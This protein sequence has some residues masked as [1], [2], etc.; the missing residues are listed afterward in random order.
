MK[1]SIQKKIIQIGLYI[2]YDIAMIA[3]AYLMAVLMFS[4]LDRPINVDGLKVA[5]PFIIIIKIVIFALTG[6]YRIMSNQLSFEDVLKFSVVNV[7]ANLLIV[8]FLALSKTEFMHKSA[9]LFISFAE[10]VLLALA[11]VVNRIIDYIK[12]HYDYPQTVGKRTLIIGAGA[13]GEAVIKELYR[14]KE[15]R[16]IPVGFL[17]DNQEKIG[18]TL[19]GVNILGP[20]D[21]IN[22]YV[23]KYNVD[24][25]IVAIN[26]FPANQF[27][28][29]E[30]LIERKSV[31]IKK[32]ISVSEYS[33]D[34]KP[35]IIDVKIDDLLERPEV[36]L[37]IERIADLIKNETVLVL[38]GGGSV[39]SELCRQIYRLSPKHLIIFDI[40]ENNAYEIQQEL[41]RQAKRLDQPLNLSV[42]IGSIY[43]KDRLQTLFE[44]FKPTVVFHAA[45]YKHVP[46]MEESAI[47]AIRTNIIGTYY[48]STLALQHEVKNFVF[49]SSDK[50]V[51]PTNMMGATKRFA[52]LII[53]EQVRQN[54][55]TKFSSVR[56]G[57]VLGSSGSVIPLFKKQ[58]EEGGP[59]TVT[60]PEITRFFMTISEA[61]GLILECG[62]FAEGGEVFIL[63]MGEPVRIVDIAEKIIS[64]A[65]YRP[66]IDIKITFTGLRPGEK[67]FEELLVDP[68]NKNQVRTQHKQI[69]IEKQETIDREKL[70]LDEI[71]AKI[72]QLTNEEAKALIADIIQTYNRFDK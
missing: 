66:H 45:A 49:V 31:K 46:L 2:I 13:S 71:I 25:V 9:Y 5:L 21:D 60:H 50:A 38:G 62:A 16:I 56:F 42:W 72:D 40:F 28:K 69:L 17:D 54:S 36:V 70:Q 55:K 19:H 53:L 32:M 8:I 68:A 41:I 23:E 63:D 20:I 57:N 29:V 15:T 11:R 6:F 44:T 27:L 3:L 24:E 67:L 26:N 10:I 30:E 48:V 1:I 43:N 4:F 33:E 39:G 47:E 34:F 14:N 35:E 65:G 64:L 51:R 22:Y 12:V 58:I 59:V 7:L 37:S 61:V 18:L 52:E